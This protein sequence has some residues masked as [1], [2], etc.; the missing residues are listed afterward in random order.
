MSAGRSDDTRLLPI[1]CPACGGPM[2]KHPALSRRDNKTYICSWC[3]EYE[4][5]IVHLHRP[6]YWSDHESRSA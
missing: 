6:E 5:M 3:G 4:A 2:P 1:V